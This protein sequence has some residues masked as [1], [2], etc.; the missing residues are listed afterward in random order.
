MRISNQEYEELQAYK[1]EVSLQEIINL[2][3]DIDFPIRNTV[4][5]LAL[6][7]ASPMFS[8]CGFD[9]RGQPA[10]KAHQYGE[11]Y[12][13]MKDDEKTREVMGRIYSRLP[14]GWKVASRRGLIYLELTSINNPHWDNPKAIHYS[15]NMVI[16]INELEKYLFMYLREFMV[17]KVVLYDT[18]AGH[19]TSLKYWQY[20]PKNPWEIT[21]DSL[22]V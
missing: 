2:E 15:E 12:V 6:A 18:N 16:S 13:M 9:Y 20:T 1:R 21:I 17:D 7:G 11:P 3:D 5:I 22:T 14:F 10:H 19:N 4:A 8:C